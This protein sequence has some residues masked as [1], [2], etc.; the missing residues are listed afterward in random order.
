MPGPPQVK[1][2]LPSLPNAP[3]LSPVKRKV[4]GGDKEPSSPAM[5][6]QAADSKTPQKTPSKGWCFILRPRRKPLPERL[7]IHSKTPQKP[8]PS[9]GCYLIPLPHQ[10]T[11]PEGVISFHDPSKKPFQRVLFHSMTLQTASS[12][13]CY[14]MTPQT[15]PF[16]GSYLIP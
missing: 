8:H 16:R 10:K 3:S 5:V 13:G 6:G 14:S 2:S 12:R 15:T 4:K 9:R 1:P 11:L 7:V